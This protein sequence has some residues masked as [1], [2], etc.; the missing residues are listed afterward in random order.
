MELITKHLH[1]YVLLF[2]VRSRHPARLG[3]LSWNSSLRE[4]RILRNHSSMHMP[5]T[6]NC[7]GMHF[8]LF[9][10]QMFNY[11]LINCTDYYRTCTKAGRCSFIPNPPPFLLHNQIGEYLLPPRGIF[12]DLFVWTTKVWPKLLGISSIK[13]SVC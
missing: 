3:E 9:W 5:A 10:D 1:V 4:P 6:Y 7:V 2:M 12:I 11:N 8:W 13:I